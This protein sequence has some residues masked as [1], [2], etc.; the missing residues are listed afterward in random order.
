MKGREEFMNICIANAIQVV[1]RDR[2]ESTI[3]NPL[4]YFKLF[5]SIASP[6]SWQCPYKLQN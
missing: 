6:E 5:V 2:V 4:F 3:P 1:M